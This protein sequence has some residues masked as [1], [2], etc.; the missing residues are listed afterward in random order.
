MADTRRDQLLFTALSAQSINDAMNNCRSREKVLILDCCY[1]G[2]F[3]GGYTAKADTAVNTLERFVGG[4]GKAVL[5]ASDATQYS[6][7]G[8][9]LHGAGLASVFT[10][11][12]VEGLR[13]G[14]ADQD[15]DGD[16]ALDE[17]YAYV[18]ERVVAEMPQQ[19]PKK[20]DDVEG[21]IVI[22]HNIRWDLPG[23]VR[24][25]LAS[26]IP[27]DRLQA[28]TNLARL[29]ANGN[30]AVRARVVAQLT[31][32]IH[33]DSKQVSQTAAELLRRCG[34]VAGQDAQPRSAI[35]RASRSS[36]SRS[37]SSMPS[38]QGRGVVDAVNRPGAASDPAGDLQAQPPGGSVR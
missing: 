11:H 31:E 4:R 1:S 9:Q 24:S 13:S 6:F 8:N 7:E 14:A 3:P 35:G 15:E 28:L 12:L 20:Q 26:P 18:Y 25:G 30:P 32:L 38:S 34:L 27:G 19:R 22:A 37:R 17:L 2:A 16:I 21:R 23:Y 10:R 5:T 33:D 29:H 36:A